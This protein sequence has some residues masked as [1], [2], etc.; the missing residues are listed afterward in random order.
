MAWL[1]AAGKGIVGL[2]DWLDW[3]FGTVCFRNLRARES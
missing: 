2:M 1:G 3:R